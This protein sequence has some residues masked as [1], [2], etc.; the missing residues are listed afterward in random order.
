MKLASVFVAN[1]SDNRSFKLS[2]KFLDCVLSAFLWPT[3]FIQYMISPLLMNSGD[4]NLVDLCSD[5]D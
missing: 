3:Y 4:L 2:Q 1:T 5:D